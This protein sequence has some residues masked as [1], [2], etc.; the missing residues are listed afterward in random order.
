MIPYGLF[1]QVLL[2]ITSVLLVL[3]YIKPAF[4]EI[5]NTQEE[6]ET[7]QA[8]IE[9]VSSV[10]SKLAALVSEYDNVPNQDK[11]KL[12]TYMPDKVDSVSVP[13]DLDAIAKRAGVNLESVSYDGAPEPVVQYDETG[14]PFF[15]DVNTSEPHTF[16]VSFE[17]SYSQLKEVLSLM[18]ENIYPLEL[19]E[20]SV[21]EGEGGFLTVE[22]QVVTYASIRELP[23]EVVF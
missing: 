9:K 18:E 6:I 14:T 16:S 7:Y 12:L 22:M 3:T 13:R 1:S 15:E 17:S 23:P 21:I 10:N 8:E 2:I 20:M 19:K 5:S 4:V 11:I